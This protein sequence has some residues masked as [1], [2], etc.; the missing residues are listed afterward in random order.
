MF[1]LNFCVQ[2]ILFTIIAAVMALG[3]VPTQ[4]LACIFPGSADLRNAAEFVDVVM[5]G[6]ASEPGKKPDNPY[7]QAGDSEFTWQPG[8]HWT[9]GFAKQNLTDSADVRQGIAEG[10]YQVAGYSTL[11][12]SDI[13]DDLYAKAIYLDDNTGRG[14]ILYAVV[15]CIGLS[16]T[17][18]RE[19]RARVWEF[20]QQAGIRSIQIAATHVHSGIDTVGLWGQLPKDGKDDAFQQLLYDKTAQALR[21]AYENRMDGDIYVSDND[22]SPAIYDSRLPEVFDK[23]MTRF[24]FEPKNGSPDVYLLN[25]GCHPE[26][27]GPG[28]QVISAD[29]PGYMAEY[30]RAYT[31]TACAGGDAAFDSTACDHAAGAE[32]FFIQGAIGGLITVRDLE[33][34]LTAAGQGNP[35]YGQTLVRGN[36]REFGQYAM[37]EAGRLSAEVQLPALLNI[38]SAE[39]SVPVE[40]IALICAAKLG[41][42]NHGIYSVKFGKYAVPC[43]LGYLRLGSRTEGADVILLP[44]EPSPELAYGGFLTAADSPAGKAYPRDSLFAL[45]EK[46]SFASSRQLVFGM[47]NNFTGYVIPENDFFLHTPFPYFNVTNDPMGRKHY[48]ETVSCGPE[49]A[50]VITEAF[51]ELLEG[52]L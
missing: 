33:S 32:T 25:A 36:G 49:T 15:D 14:G 10:R 16:D 28:Q 24:R 5:R 7:F 52:I 48:E 46:T 6:A 47:A 40:N 44:G 37:G 20:A 45:L 17:D 22:V 34:V 30:I 18:A 13:L 2:K 35:G 4:L 21:A 19:I 51:A 50:R 11:P 29:F 38:A 8:T 9:L 23:K 1:L 41:V 43:E 42:L 39:F 27:M 3:W 31:C 12:S 26:I